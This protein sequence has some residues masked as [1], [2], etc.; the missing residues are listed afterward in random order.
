[1]EQWRTAPVASIVGQLKEQGE[2]LSGKVG[3]HGYQ[4]SRLDTRIQDYFS[5]RPC[6]SVANRVSVPSNRIC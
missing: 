4:L 2:R 5:A 6:S 3:R 1:L